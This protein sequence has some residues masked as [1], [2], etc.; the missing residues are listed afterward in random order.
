MD[1]RVKVTGSGPSS[2]T[3]LRT[4]GEEEDLGSR[5]SRQFSKRKVGN[6]TIASGALMGWKIPGRSISPRWVLA[7]LREEVSS[8]DNKGGGMTGSECVLSFMKKGS[9]S[10][11]GSHS[12]FTMLGTHQTISTSGQQEQMSPSVGY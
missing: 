9:G 5:Q 1:N 6:Q 3:D 8:R 2:A 4:L 10:D 12:P 7:G 11:F